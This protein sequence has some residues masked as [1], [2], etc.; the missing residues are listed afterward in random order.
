MTRQP[1]R[2]L[3]SLAEWLVG[4]AERLIGFAEWLGKLAES[5]VSANCRRRIST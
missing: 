5:P 1:R 3:V 2:R 4:F